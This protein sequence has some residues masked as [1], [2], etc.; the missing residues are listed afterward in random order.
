MMLC[1]CAMWTSWC[2]MVIT[3]NVD[4]E[5]LIYLLECLTKV[6]QSMYSDI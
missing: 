4:D 1:I 3:I 2:R 6:V 5:I